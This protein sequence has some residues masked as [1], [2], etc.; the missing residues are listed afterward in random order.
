[1]SKRLI[2]SFEVTPVTLV[3]V[4]DTRARISEGGRYQFEVSLSLQ[5][6]L[7]LVPTPVAGFLFWNFGASS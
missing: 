3:Y 1:M 4:L 5:A 6:E 2:L 7:F